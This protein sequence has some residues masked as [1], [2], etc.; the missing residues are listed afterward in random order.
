MQLVELHEWLMPMLMN[1]Q[2]KWGEV[3]VNKIVSFFYFEYIKYACV[4]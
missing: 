3:L 4:Q 1:G 2:V